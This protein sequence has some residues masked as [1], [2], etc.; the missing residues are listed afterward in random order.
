MACSTQRAQARPKSEHLDA[1]DATQ[2]AMHARV[3]VRVACVRV[4]VC[5]CVELETWTRENAKRRMPIVCTVNSASAR[6]CHC[7]GSTWKETHMSLEPLEAL[8]LQGLLYTHIAVSIVALRLGA[9]WP[10][11]RAL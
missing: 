6:S 2:G 7:Q 10:V 9:T 5:V 8:T 11:N 3:L 4:C 1:R